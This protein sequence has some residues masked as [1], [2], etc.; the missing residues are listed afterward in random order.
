MCFK[1]A[2]TSNRDTSRFCYLSFI[3]RKEHDKKKHAHDVSFCIMIKQLLKKTPKSYEI[4]L[5]S[6]RFSSGMKIEYQEKRKH[7]LFFKTRY[8]YTNISRKGE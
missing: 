2:T 6:Y 8:L 1:V 7:F 3:Y 4:I 5:F